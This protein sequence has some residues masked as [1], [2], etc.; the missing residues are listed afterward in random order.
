MNELIKVPMLSLHTVA[1][2]CQYDDSS[3]IP[4]YIYFKSQF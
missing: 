4:S 2:S 1:L 3:L